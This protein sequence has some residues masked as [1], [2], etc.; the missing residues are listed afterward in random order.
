MQVTLG[1]D[2][3]CVKKEQVPIEV[4]PEKFFVSLLPSWELRNVLQNQSHYPLLFAQKY[5]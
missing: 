5:K 2:S 4:H 1:E 3:A